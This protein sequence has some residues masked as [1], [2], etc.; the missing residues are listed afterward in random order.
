MSPLRSFA[1][2]CCW[3]T[4][5]RAARRRLV[6][7]VL[8]L[9]VAAWGAAPAVAQETS[10]AAPADQATAP[11]DSAPQA[12]ETP[13]SDAAEASGTQPSTPQAAGSGNTQQTESQPSPAS[14]TDGESKPA[15]DQSAAP[16][17]GAGGGA[18]QPAGGT[19]PATQE[20]PSGTSQPAAAETSSSPTG[21]EQT[22]TAPP[23][24]DQ[25][26]APTEGS[27]AAQGAGTPS[28]ANQPA[29]ETPSASSGENAAAAGA[30]PSAA[31]QPGTTPSAARGAAAP[32]AQAGD[33]K[34]TSQDNKNGA[35]AQQPS[36]QGGSESAQVLKN[37][38]KPPEQETG[39]Q[40]LGI[41]LISNKIVVEITQGYIHTTNNQL[42]IDGFGVIPILVVGNVSVKQVRKDIFSTTFALR[43]K[44][45]DRLQA[46]VSLPYTYTITR[47]SEPTGVTANSSVNPNQDTL[48]YSG[49]VGDVSIGVNYSLKDEGLSSPALVT[50]LN[51]KGRN[52]RDIFESPDSTL[53]P[54][55]GSG[56]FSV[57]GSLSA[58][59]TSA[60]AIVFGSV[61]Y[62][63][64]FPRY[65]VVF[66]PANKPPA[67]VNFE[68]GNNFNLSMGMALSLNYNFTLNMSYAQS[69]NLSSHINGIKLGNS[70]TDAITLR[71]G[72]TWRFSTKTSADVGI[73]F[74]LTPDAP[75]FRL[76]VRVPLKFGN[77]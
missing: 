48:G 68:P 44:V 10:T 2:H 49:G 16:A 65:N 9:A 25:S 20:P 38:E 37:Q 42:F 62:N 60:P 59:K 69:V 6:A 36:D 39:L 52:G 19:A 18:E 34:A 15:S 22:G 70:A 50:G 40:S 56:F 3:Y 4:A 76:D 7:T 73:S 46:S 12:Q 24:P 45:T 75:D 77:A 63:Y 5:L 29:A 53:H 1:H 26:A 57:G 67:L 54:P 72:G 14:G 55:T 61:G 43:Y 11:A 41:N 32:A 28:S 31:A 64:A 47:L 51:F 33:Q 35:A 58:S 30:A 8:C 23:A 71:I 27:G 13:P 21:K 74:G 66:T 17:E